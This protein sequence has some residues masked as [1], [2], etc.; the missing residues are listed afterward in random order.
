MKI[1][2]IIPTKKIGRVGAYD[3]ESRKKQIAKRG[4]YY[5]FDTI[6]YHQEWFWNN[7]EKDI[8]VAYYEEQFVKIVIC[9]KGKKDYK[10]FSYTDCSPLGFEGYSVFHIND[11]LLRTAIENIERLREKAKIVESEEYDRAKRLVILNSIEDKD[12]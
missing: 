8:V 11:I 7:A 2:D 3:S 5:K 10:C 12:G 1:I 4:Y 9:K 6:S